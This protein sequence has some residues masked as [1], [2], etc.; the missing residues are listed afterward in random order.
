MDWNDLRFLLAL[1]RRGSLNAAAKELGV[2][3]TT[4]SR[5]LAALEESLGAKLFDRRPNG[6]RLTPMGHD[7]VAV[8]TKVAADVETLAERATTAADDK[9]RGVVR[10]TAPPW[11]AARV[12]V[13]A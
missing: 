8:A 5:R 12:I 1:H 11:L 6:L 10:L 3:K 9:A 2:T 13:P 7:A 4:M